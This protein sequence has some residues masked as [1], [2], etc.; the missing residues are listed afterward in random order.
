MCAIP[1]STILRSPDIGEGAARKGD[2]K[3][4]CS[5]GDAAKTE[6]AGSE[7]DFFQKRVDGATFFKKKLVARRRRRRHLKKSNLVIH[8]MR[9][10]VITC[11]CLWFVGGK[12]RI[13]TMTLSND[14]RNAFMIVRA[15]P[16]FDCVIADVYRSSWMRNKS[17]QLSEFIWVQCQRRF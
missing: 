14:D 8:M 17:S 9:V 10:L 13:L 6:K 5:L 16:T 1:S 11:L 7:V 12:A 3:T 15:L 4:Y 2:L